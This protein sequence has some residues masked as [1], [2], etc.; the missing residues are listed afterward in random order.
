M[1]QQEG[2]PLAAPALAPDVQQAEIAARQERRT[3][4]AEE[5]QKNQKCDG[6]DPRLVGQWV[7]EITL[8]H[9]NPDNEAAIY[10]L[11]ATTTGP[12]RA[13][14]EAY[15]SIQPDRNLAQWVDIRAHM[16]GAFV[17]ADQAEYYR[18]E[19][20]KIKQT[21]AENILAY[22]RRFRAAATEAFPG[23]RNV[24][25]NRELVRLY[26][27]KLI[28]ANT[29]RKLVANKWP[30]TLDDAFQRMRDWRRKVCSPG[31]Y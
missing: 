4:I 13:E 10:L 18:G 29:A 6:A 28:S 21:P 1:A 27:K 22:N 30:A 19:L 23:V 5:V 9:G 16:L 31:A 12:F 8:A 15:L 17:S 26:G 7:Q 24:E 11:T 3:I 25:R 20:A 14:L 2:G